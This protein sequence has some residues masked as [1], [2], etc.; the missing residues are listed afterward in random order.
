MFKVLTPPAPFAGRRRSV[1]RL[2]ILALLLA[3]AL[4][5]PP[6]RGAEARRYAI[7]F[8]NLT[9]EPGVL[10]EGTGFTGRD[11]RESFVLAARLL[12][13]DLVL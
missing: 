4:P 7:A 3:S 10:L 12:P 8:A 6:A 11:V 5:A 2:G 9:E 13:V 1:L